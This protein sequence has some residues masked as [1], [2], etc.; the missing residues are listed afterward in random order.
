MILALEI[1]D[2]ILLMVVI[3][4]AFYC[5]ALSSENETLAKKMDWL[6]NQ[7]E[8]VRAKQRVFEK[9]FQAMSQPAEKLVIEHKFEEKDA[10]KFGR[11]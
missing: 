10:P 3:M 1:M 5:K 6:N 9:R 2:L 11:F 8:Q 7:L 4:G